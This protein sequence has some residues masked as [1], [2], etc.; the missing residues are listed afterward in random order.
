MNEFN[1]RAISN[2]FNENKLK[3]IDFESV[4]YWQNIEDPLTVNSNYTYMNDAGE[5]VAGTAEAVN[6][7]GVIFDE[8][9]LG[10]TIANE[11]RA[12]TPL[13]PASGSWSFRRAC[14]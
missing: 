8:E 7:L 3:M 1:A 2:T 12:M 14:S 13:N 5:L 4:T 11:W 6:V 9:A 10:I